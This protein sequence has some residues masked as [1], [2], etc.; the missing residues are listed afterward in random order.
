VYESTTIAALATAPYPSGVAIIRVS[1]PDARGAVQSLFKSNRCP[2]AHPREMIYGYFVDEDNQRIVDSGLCFFSVAPRSYTGEDVAE[3]QFHGSPLL[4][5]RILR[6]LYAKGVLPAPPG[7]FTKRAFLNGRMDLLQAEAIG[8]LINA[9]SEQGLRLAGEQLRGKLS[10]VIKSIGDPLR[11]LMA[12][13]EAHIDFPEEDIDP[14]SLLGIQTSAITIAHALSELLETF[15]FGHILKEGYRVLLCGRPNVGKSSLL[16]ALLGYD[17]A[18]V[19]NYEG[20]TR[21]TLEEQIHLGGYTFLICDSA[22]VRDATHPVEKLGIELTLGR[23]EWADLV[24]LVIDA[25]TDTQE[26][27]DEITNTISSRAKQIWLVTNKVDLNPQAIGPLYCQSPLCAQNF[28]LS[29]VTGAGIEDLIQALIDEISTLPEIVAE[30][31]IALT[32]ERHRSCLDRASSDLRSFIEG[33]QSSLSLDLLSEHLRRSLSA[34]DELI[35][36][37]AADDILGLIFS[38]FC[39]GK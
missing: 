3:F 39:I 22:G 17:R 24:L 20:T 18:I 13:L 26:T 29:A 35:G 32:S 38:K 7:E 1:G 14:D 2:V 30:H 36:V 27:I 33:V 21:D 16:N 8:D 15:A 31:G 34:L 12:E 10:A 28:Y 25:T 19:S 6:S 9:S 4:V 5:Q 11:V 23:L 37:T